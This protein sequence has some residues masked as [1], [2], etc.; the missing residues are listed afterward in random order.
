MS[1]NTKTAFGLTILKNA[2]PVIR[3]IRRESGQPNIHGN[4]FWK[5]TFLLMDYL[6]GFSL[7]KKCRVLEIGCGWGLAGIYCA[8]T[9]KANVTSL[10]ADDLVF[11]YLEHHAAIN[12]V[13]VDT[14]KCRYEGVKKTDLEKFDLLIAT[15]VCFWDSM[16]KPL[17]NLINRSQKMGVRCVMTD[18][19]RQPF[20]DVAE[21]CV[22]KFD[23]ACK[24]WSVPHP[25]NASGFVLD[26]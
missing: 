26:V 9:F 21:K 19:G 4:K 6:N 1:E 14:W 8:K 15:D 10:D 7:K 22:D 12:G 18:P 2:H 24:N 3:R 5:S 16:V 11:P 20:L 17:Y 25:H 13:E 23:A